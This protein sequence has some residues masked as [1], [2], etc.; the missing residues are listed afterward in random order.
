MTLIHTR[1]EA[2]MSLR[3]LDGFA[4]EV[5]GRAHQVAPAA[6]RL[7]AY[8]ALRGSALTRSQVAGVLW[9]DRT[10]ERAA[11]CLRSAIWRANCGLEQPLVR[12]GRTT[13]A[14]C[15]H[16][17]DTR[18]AAAAAHDQFVGRPPVD[19]VVLGGNLLPGWDDEWVLVE[20]ERLRLLCLGGLER[21]AESLLVAGEYYRAIEAA[22]AVLAADSLREAAYRIVIEAHAHLGNR[23]EALRQFKLCGTMLRRELGLDPGR[24]LIAVVQR[25]LT[26]SR[27]ES[28][29][30]LPTSA[31]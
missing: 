1:P 20:R 11:A 3:L 14:L 10:E 18:A 7:I 15:P 8:L 23:A 9:G 2:A 31:V 29:T 5:E 16:R 19:P 6:A 4:L 27:V 28:R 17:L 22:C 30:D 13:V 25:L 21:M 26:E 24:E 12:A